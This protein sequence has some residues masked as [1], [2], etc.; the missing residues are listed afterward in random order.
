[1]SGQIMEAIMQFRVCRL[2][3]IP[4]CRCAASCLVV[5]AGLLLV[6][7][8]AQAQILYG[9]LTGN[10]LDPSGAVLPGAHVEA[11]LVSTGVTKQATTNERGVYLFPLLQPGIYKVTI[12]APS[13][14][15]VANENVRVDANSTRR[16]DVQLQL[17]KLNE[18]V[19][20]QSSASDRPGRR[21]YATAN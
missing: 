17:A 2:V 20:V 4:F 21:V 16:V 6:S 7:G 13:F 1:M 14:A 19:T 15:P 11:L 3:K 10:V 5:L 12:S 8:A 18:V 9:S